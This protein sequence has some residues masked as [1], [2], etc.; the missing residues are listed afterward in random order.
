[1][2]IR[3]AT[4]GGSNDEIVVAAIKAPAVENDHDPVGVLPTG[5][6]GGGV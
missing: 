6:C 2:R 1:V 3:H 5:P 4:S